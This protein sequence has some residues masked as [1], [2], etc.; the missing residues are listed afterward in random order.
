MNNISFQGRT[1]LIFDN[2]IYDR[3]IAKR[4]N[5]ASI[6]L[7]RRPTDNCRIFRSKYSALDVNETQDVGVLLLGDKKDGIFFQNASEKI[8]DILDSIKEMQKNATENLT[9]WIIGGKNNSQTT[10]EVNTL[11]EILCDRADIDASIIA[12]KKQQLVPNMTFHPVAGKLDMS[13]SMPLAKTQISKDLENYYE[14]VEL[15]NT[16]I[17]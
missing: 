9:A 7:N 14:I 1:N 15:N 13:F 16:T 4:H 11:A 17:S 6:D 12:G 3:A 8:L 10:Q 2:K 5:Y